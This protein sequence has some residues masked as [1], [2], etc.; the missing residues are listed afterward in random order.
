MNMT[1]RHPARLAPLYAPL[2]RPIN[3]P[4]RGSGSYTYPRHTRRAFGSI[5]PLVRFIR[6]WSY[7]PTIRDRPSHVCPDRRNFW[8][9]E[10]RTRGNIIVYRFKSAWCG[11]V[12][13]YLGYCAG[14]HQTSEAKR[15]WARIVLEWVTFREVLVTNPPS[16]N[17]I[18]VSFQHPSSQAF[19]HSP[20]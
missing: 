5:R 1:G 11:V 2:D 16:C 15:L 4:V 19:L 14:S 10:S 12:R 7:S 8:R 6:L 17:F 18:F 20:P 3:R 9:T 13:S